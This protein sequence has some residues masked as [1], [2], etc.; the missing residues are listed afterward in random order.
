MVVVAADE[1]ARLLAKEPAQPSLVAFLRASGL[2]DLDVSCE[3][4][5]GRETDL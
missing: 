2:G 4:D 1:F 3:L 5:R